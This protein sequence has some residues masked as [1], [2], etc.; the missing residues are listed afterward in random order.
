MTKKDSGFEE[1]S[2]GL[3]VGSKRQ[4]SDTQ[5]FP[6]ETQLAQGNIWKLLITQRRIQGF[7]G[8]LNRKI[9]F[10]LEERE[11]KREKG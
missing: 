2:R 4:A 10:T 1:S 8:K 9:L 6:R 5:V 11:R 7:R 3:A